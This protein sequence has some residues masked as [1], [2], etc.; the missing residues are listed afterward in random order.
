MVKPF[1]KYRNHRII[2]SPR[3]LQR[4]NMKPVKDERGLAQGERNGLIDAICSCDLSS[5]LH[6]MTLLMVR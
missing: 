1:N 3:P 4:E 5:M 6:A 2:I